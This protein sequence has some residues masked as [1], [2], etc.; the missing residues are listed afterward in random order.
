MQIQTILLIVL[1]FVLALGIAVFHYKNSKA[2][3]KRRIVLTAL[4][5]LVFFCGMLLLINPEFV[6]NNYRT[7]KSNL[8]LLVDASSSISNLEEENT[9]KGLIN[10]LSENN[11]LRNK[12]SVQSYS[13]SKEIQPFDSLFFEGSTTDIA[14]ALETTKELFPN[15]NNAV[16]LISD[17]NQTYGK[18][19]EYFDLGKSSKL[20][21]VVIGDTT[22]YQDV[23]ISLTNTN[24][25][26]F[27]DNQFPLEVQAVFRGETTA[28]TNAKITMEGRVVHRETLEFSSTNR[29]HTL[30]IL[31]KAQSTGIKNIRI[32][33]DTLNN[34]KNK[35]NNIKDIAIEVIDEK[36]VVG[37]VSSFRHPDLGALKKAIESNEQREVVFLS[38]DA[39]TEKLE[40]VDVFILYQPNFE[41]ENIYRFLNERGGGSFTITG[42][43][44]D[45]N[46]L[47]D[48]LRGFTM[49]AFGQNEE[50]LTIKNEAFELFDISN[51]K[52]DDFPPLDGELGEMLFSE[53]PKV[54][55]YQRIRG[56]DLREPLFFV[57]DGE[58]KRAFL[59]GENLW[60]WRLSA[61]RNANSFSN[62]DAFMGKLMF[63]LSSSGKKERLQLDY[64]NVFENAAEAVIRASFFDKVFDFDNNARLILNVTG[65]NGFERNAP[66]LLSGNQ[67]EMGL[68]DLE[69]GDYSFTITET[70]E[71]I[72]RSGQFKILNF[73]LEKQFMIAN[74]EKMGRLAESNSGSLF[75]P[76]QVMELVDDLVD[77][78][79]FLP[80]QKSTKNVVSLI[81]FKTVLGIMA[82]ALALEWFIRKYN[83][84]L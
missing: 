44:T 62:F 72:S 84:L 13:F 27:L 50:I 29:S 35:G 17:G 10:E 79:Q 9:V 83:G 46:Y 64:E 51:F 12:F 7:E 65:D 37:V 30:S 80:V 54:I 58:D 73:D 16:I 76:D 3:L 45:W 74:Y 77:D 71:R 61:Y 67:Y 36:T 41:F 59:L 48:K 8:I 23:G 25:Y 56:V 40:E 20:S 31:L 70:R 2:D 19:Y 39:S 1:A 14:Q 11:A 60:K 52:M 69:E 49:E 6:K 22:S 78:N 5:F 57:L 32:E 66:M 82:L 43:Q 24:R 68:S 4:R 63:Y 42:N 53:N 21:T 81:D 47:N 18:D 55:S 38:P 33:L 75:F 28:S 34:E 15:K 26:A